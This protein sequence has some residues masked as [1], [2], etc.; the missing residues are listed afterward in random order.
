MKITIEI[1]NNED[2]T[3]AIQYLKLLVTEQAPKVTTPKKAT[4]KKETPKAELKPSA[5]FELA[6]ELAKKHGSAR[7]KEVIKKY[8]E[9]MADI[10]LEDLVA[11]NK[12]LSS[13]S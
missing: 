3:E 10:K 6:K 5:V 7:V 12:D 9:K 4:V 11:F 1:N 8:G 2:I 13:L